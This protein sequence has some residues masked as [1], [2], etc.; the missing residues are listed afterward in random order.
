MHPRYVILGSG[1]HARVLLDT[2][3]CLGLDAA[4]FSDVRPDLVG[5]QLNGVPIVAEAELA[6]G[7]SGAFPPDATLLVNGIGGVKD[8]S[9][10]R[11]V[12]RRFRELGYSFA[13]L[14]HPAAFVAAD[15]QLGEGAQ[16][17]AGAVL[18][19]G[20]TVGE[21]SIINTRACVDHD[22]SIGAHCHIAPGVTLSGSVTVGECTLV[23]TGAAVIQGIRIGSRCVIGAGAAVVSN[24]PSHS[25]ATGVPARVH[26]PSLPK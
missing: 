6:E 20:A 10:R 4:A 18:I 19:T 12:F 15:V 9:P 25:T 26:P 2:M 21:N 1:G 14:V 5:G 11:N 7:A 23:G 17:M 22:C 24:I 13:T 16:V 3:R 8:M